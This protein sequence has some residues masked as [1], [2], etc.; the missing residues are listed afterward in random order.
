MTL[1][2]KTERRESCSARSETE[3]CPIWL[4][5]T[6]VIGSARCLCANQ[7]GR[8]ACVHACMP[9]YCSDRQLYFLGACIFIFTC[10]AA[11]SACVAIS[12]TCFPLRIVMLRAA[13]VMLVSAPE[14]LGQMCAR[15]RRVPTNGSARG[16]KVV[17]ASPRR[18]SLSHPWSRPKARMP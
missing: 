15:S 2:N 8:V 4:M 16:C 3:C 18:L 7:P 13:L 17:V 12:C 6:A 11:S 5:P 9:S 1:P 10:A 14:A